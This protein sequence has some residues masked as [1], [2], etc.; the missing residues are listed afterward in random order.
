MRFMHLTIK[1]G[2]GG[3]MVYGLIGAMARYSMARPYAGANGGGI[4]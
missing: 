3:V 4:S 1:G 2:L